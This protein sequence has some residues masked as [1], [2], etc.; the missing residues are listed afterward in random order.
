[1]GSQV[2]YTFRESIKQCV[3]SVMYL[4][5]KYFNRAFIQRHKCHGCTLLRAHWKR[6]KWRHWQWE[7]YCSLP[8]KLQA[9]L[10]HYMKHAMWWY[11]IAILIEFH[12][13]DATSCTLKPHPSPLHMTEHCTLKLQRLST[14]CSKMDP[15]PFYGC[16][17]YLWCFHTC[18]WKSCRR[19]G[20]EC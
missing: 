17:V 16:F 2:A 18:N 14:T 7:H 13:G 8:G 12:Y 10:L 5:E 3:L 1:M 15:H 11:F 20:M 9:H 4:R 19:L 6:V